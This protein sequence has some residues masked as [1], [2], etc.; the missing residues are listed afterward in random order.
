MKFEIPHDVF[1]AALKKG[2][3]ATDSKDAKNP[4]TTRKQPI[5]RCVKLTTDNAGLTIESSATGLAARTFVPKTQVKIII[6][7][8]LCVEAPEMIEELSKLKFQHTIQVEFDHDQVKTDASLAPRMWVRAI[9]QK[10][11]EAFAWS[12]DVYPT[13][14]FP[15]IAY[16]NETPQFAV[17]AKQ[18][19]KIVEA[20]S[21]TKRDDDQHVLDN[22]LIG[23]VDKILHLATT[24]TKRGAIIR[25]TEG[26]KVNSNDDLHLVN[27]EIL[28]TALACFDESDPLEF[29]FEPDGEHLTLRGQN[30]I[31]S[32]R[33]ALP[34]AALI[35][36]FGRLLGL[37]K[38]PV[39]F[40]VTVDDRTEL[41]QAMMVMEARGTTANYHFKGGGEEIM[42][43]YSKR[44]RPAMVGCQKIDGGLSDPILLSVKFFLDILQKIESDGVII[45]VAE[46]ERRVFLYDTVDP[47][48]FYMMVKL[49][50]QA[51][52][53]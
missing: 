48:Y 31:T 27:W 15:K 24:D 28:N 51:P 3:V 17:S 37:R 38:T 49:T 9:N 23:P 8:S 36:K 5:L 21:F 19:R 29:V 18:I 20:V 26:V 32:L 50:S 35:E 53:V 40:S 52:A 10:G 25:L 13:R 12:Y 7:D 6:A 14:N 47:N 30:N 4:E 41:L 42:I 16:S 45:S 46:D 22:V 43:D 1:Y 2:G 44:H 11:R 34:P 39:K 33:L